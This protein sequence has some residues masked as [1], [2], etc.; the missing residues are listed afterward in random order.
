MKTQLSNPFEKEIIETSTLEDSL[1][2][3]STS[4]AEIL[5][6]VQREPGRKDHTASNHADLCGVELAV[7]DLRKAL[8]NRKS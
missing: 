6:M 3:L 1:Q 2:A 8:N 7:A 5:L 4:A